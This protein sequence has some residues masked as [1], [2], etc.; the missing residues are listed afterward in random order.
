MC[1]EQIDAVDLREL[2][3]T[4]R[5]MLHTHLQQHHKQ[6]LALPLEKHSTTETPPSKRKK[7][8]SSGACTV[9]ACRYELRSPQRRKSPGKQPHTLNLKGAADSGSPSVNS[10]VNGCGR[11]SVHKLV[12]SW[13]SVPDSA[14]DLLHRCLELSPSK[15]I[16]AQDALE[17][18]FLADVVR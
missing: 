5:R 13:E 14:Y 12:K 18:P 6:Q 9:T 4:L 15:R 10:S 2:C 16:T 1:G 7:L 8:S 11:I 3:R 17:H